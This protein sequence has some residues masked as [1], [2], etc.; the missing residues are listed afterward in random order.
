MDSY[1]QDEVVQKALEILDSISQSFVLDDCDHLYVHVDQEGTR[2]LVSI[3]E[4]EDEK[5]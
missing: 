1:G 5:E 4:R 3:P 2:R